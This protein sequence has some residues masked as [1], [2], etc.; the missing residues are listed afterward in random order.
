MSL[1]TATNCISKTEDQFIT[2][3]ANVSAFQTWQGN[4]WSAD[5]AKDRI[6]FDEIAQSIGNVFDASNLCDLRP[7]AFCTL[8]QYEVAPIG[9]P[10]AFSSAGEILIRFEAEMELDEPNPG[11]A[12]RTFKNQIGGIMD[13]LKSS[14]TTYWN[15]PTITIHDWG[16]PTPEQRAGMGEFMICLMAVTW[17]NGA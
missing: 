7:F 6:Y 10:N 13:G 2:W 9:S 1:P 3:L 16:T 17:G 14:A 15:S 8:E 4:S 5:Q 12:Y 11:R